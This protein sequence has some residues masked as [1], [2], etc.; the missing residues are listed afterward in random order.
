MQKGEEKSITVFP[1]KE[2]RTCRLC[3][4]YGPLLS[5]AFAV[6]R[7]PVGGFEAVF[8]AAWTDVACA[9]EPSAEPMAL[10]PLPL[11][12][13]HSYAQMNARRCRRGKEYSGMQAEPLH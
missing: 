11:A 1:A 5:Y 10:L 12:A 7:V 13:L 2:S 9:A 8:S 6:V 4:K 3:S